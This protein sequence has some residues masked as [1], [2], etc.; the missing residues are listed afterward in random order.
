MHVIH[1]IQLCW[2]VTGISIGNTD[3]SFEGILRWIHWLEPH[4]VT[5]RSG[6]VIAIYSKIFVDWVEQY[7]FVVE[8]IVKASYIH[9]QNITYTVFVY[10][11]FCLLRERTSA[12][13]TTFNDCYTNEGCIQKYPSLIPLKAGYLLRTQL[14]T[15]HITFY[16][17]PSFA[18]AAAYSGKIG[19]QRVPE[20][21][22]Q[23]VPFSIHGG[24][25]MH[26]IIHGLTSAETSP[27]AE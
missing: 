8:K 4:K 13:R 14:K 24:D 12:D 11:R 16:S 7:F 27:S 6:Y 22:P 19:T 23:K 21:T 26:A 3:Y 15:R 10:V 2:T 25:V 9:T 20:C 5:P 1:T 17:V 18:T